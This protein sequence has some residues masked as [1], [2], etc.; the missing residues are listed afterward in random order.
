MPSN[1][2]LEMADAIAAAKAKLAL[3]A[4]GLIA[5]EKG[6]PTVHFFRRSRA[7]A[8]EGGAAQEYQAATKVAFH[9]PATRS[10]RLVSATGA[11]SFHFAHHAISKVSFATC[12]EGRRNKP[13][14]ARAH[15]R[16]VEREAAVALV[17]ATIDQANDTSPE[18]HITLTPADLISAPAKDVEHDDSEQR[19]P[20]RWAPLGLVEELAVSEPGPAGPLLGSPV[21]D[22]L[23]DARMWLLPRGD[24]VRHGSGAHGLLRSAADVSLETGK[25]PLGLRCPSA[26][27][28]GQGSAIDTA[29]LRSASEAAAHDDYIGRVGATAI[30]PDGTRA[31][32]TNIDPDD[33]ERARFWALV[34]E[35]EAS[36]QGDKMS[37]RIKDRPDFWRLV[38]MRADCPPELKAAI[39]TAD[40]D[41]IVRFEIASGE[42]MRAFLATQSGWV[43][44]PSGRQPKGSEVP[45]AKFHDGRRGRVQYRT[46][47]E[48]PNELGVAGRFAIMREFAEE[49]EKRNLP[50][51]AVMHAPDHNNDEK[52]WHFHLIYYD[53]PCRRITNEDLNTLKNRGYRTDHLEPGMWD[54][55]VVTPKKGRSNGREVPLK[56]KKVS[57]VSHR[58]WIPKLRKRLAVATNR[59]LALAGI[60]RRIDPRRHEQMGIIADPQEHLGSQQAAAETRGDVTR[61][62][63]ENERRQWDAI[64]R[65]A[66]TGLALALETIAAPADRK[67]SGSDPTPAPP[68][69]SLLEAARLDHMAFCIE[70]EIERARS[71]ANSVRR[72]NGQLL[73][74]YSADPLAGS[75]RERRDAEFL[76]SAAT[77]Y[78]ARLD[79]ALGAD[80]TLPQQCRDAAAELRS[81]QNSDVEALSGSITRSG[82]EPVRPPTAADNLVDVVQDRALIEEMLQ[83]RR[84]DDEALRTH[85]EAILEREQSSQTPAA[86]AKSGPEPNR[87]GGTAG[88]A[89]KRAAIAAALKGQGR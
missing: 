15:G 42:A 54:F 33:H 89:A 48:L 23:S 1:R 57:E 55:T 63:S 87:D 11:T 88:D 78:L 50:F 16:Y 77:D 45:F 20:D 22:A 79:Q 35:H 10:Y 67:L 2:Y 58:D 9:K 69:E 62:G 14:A 81:D 8:P 75:P 60:E 72:K 7:V 4:E 73:Q 80:L 44:R 65:Q 25:D 5:N 49:F 71:R 56:Q 18:P 39:D 52:N 40:P 64:M 27:D 12:E 85:R 32:L 21:E 43:P 47:G 53:R 46:V 38:S 28:R 34:E 41:E 61:V 84:R 86:P 37:L 3:I 82:E 19:R 29:S 26:G 76:T 74:A 36:S 17:S 83:A 24:L 30:Q 68:T 59:H 51:V 31:L 6:E 13:G 70:Q 66:D